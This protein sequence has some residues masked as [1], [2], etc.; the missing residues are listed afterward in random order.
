MKYRRKKQILNKYRFLNNHKLYFSL[1]DMKQMSELKIV[2][3]YFYFLLLTTKNILLLSLI[4]VF[5][6]IHNIIY[7]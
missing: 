5:S 7:N 3:Q 2:H 4:K 1:L 6:S